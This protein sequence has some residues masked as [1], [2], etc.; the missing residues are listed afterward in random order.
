MAIINSSIHRLLHIPLDEAAIKQET[1]IIRSIAQTNGLKINVEQLIR[2]K[3]LQLLLA[4]NSDNSPAS[5]SRN[6][7]KWLRLP[8]L[9]QGSKKLAS[10]LQ[11]FGYKVGFYPITTVSNLFD[12]KDPTPL[13]ERSGMYRASCGECDAAYYGQTGRN[14]QTRIGEHRAAYRSKLKGKSRES[15]IAD[16]C[17]NTNHSIDRVE[18]QII[19]SLEKGRS[20]HRLE[21]SEI[22]RALSNQENIM[23]DASAT[24]HN[25]FVQYYFNTVKNLPNLS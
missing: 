22:T 20:M 16:H 12:L 8:F 19:H 7:P 3:R 6:K 1:Q 23:N 25:P 15:A 10:E 4:Q 24:F 2:R 14:L 5:I 9:G 21:E 17:I 13:P 18:F 11:R